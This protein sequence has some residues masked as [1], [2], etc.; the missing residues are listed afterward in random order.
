[1]QMVSQ[2]VV[3]FYF[4]TIIC[5]KQLRCV[6]IKISKKLKVGGCDWSPILPSLKV[7]KKIKMIFFDVESAVNIFIAKNY[8]KI[9]LVRKLLPAKPAKRFLKYC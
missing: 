5:L 8:C 3:T 1:M 9:F 4:D 6:I 7:M 2:T